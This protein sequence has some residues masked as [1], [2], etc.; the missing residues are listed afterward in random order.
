[1]T[2][3]K[4]LPPRPP[5]TVSLTIRL[6]PAAH[7]KLVEIA[8]E[9]A[10]SIAH[11]ARDLIADALELTDEERVTRSRGWQNIHLRAE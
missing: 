1:M 4:P 11:V 7:A 5:A 10:V 8:E 6:P 9:H 2:N 3:R